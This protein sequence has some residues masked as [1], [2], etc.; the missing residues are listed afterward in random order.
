MATDLRYLLDTNVII[1]I[2]DG[3]DP[4]L[5]QRLGEAD[6]G[7]LATSSVALAETMVKLDDRTRRRLANLLRQIVVL[8][9]D[10]EAAEVYGHL[11][12]KRRS[13]DRL[14]A[15][16]ALSRDLTVVTANAVDFAGIAG[17]KQENWAG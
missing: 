15:A 11:P 13:F 4:V 8:P 7:L 1:S 5:E 3:D 14:I 2:L 16:H 9:F 17:L 6:A 10:T 12:F